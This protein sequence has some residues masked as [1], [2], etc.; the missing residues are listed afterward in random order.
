MVTRAEKE[1]AE[2]SADL[3]AKVISI[4]QNATIHTRHGERRAIIQLE[5]LS[6]FIASPDSS[7][8][9][10]KKLWP[11]LNEEQADIAARYLVANVKLHFRQAVRCT[12]W[13]SRW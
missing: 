4:L 10:V 1:A 11:S 9:A 7:L 2:E 5:G 6:G 12:S 3:P 13:A 8:A